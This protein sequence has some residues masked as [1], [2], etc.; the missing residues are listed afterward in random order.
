[1]IHH[2]PGFSALGL[3]VGALEDVGRRVQQRLKGRQVR[4][5]LDDALPGHPGVREPVLFPREKGKKARGIGRPPFANTSPGKNKNLSSSDSFPLKPT[6]ENKKIFLTKW[7]S[8]D[9]FLSGWA[10][11]RVQLFAYR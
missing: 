10:K 2:D 11:E 4:A 7:K 9:F 1:M 5:L 8:T 6:G 3:D